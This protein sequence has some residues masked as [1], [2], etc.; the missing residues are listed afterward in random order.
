MANTRIEFL[1]KSPIKEELYIVGNVPAL[2]DWNPAKGAKLSFCEECGCYT[3]SKLLPIDSNVEFK[4][5]AGKSWEHV[6]KGTWGEEVANHA[7]VVAKGTKV[8]IEVFNF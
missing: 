1:V 5:V 2:G 8:E 7:F 4:V 6:E 3:A